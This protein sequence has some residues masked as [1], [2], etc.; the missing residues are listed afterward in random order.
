MTKKIKKQIVVFKIER[1]NWALEILKVQEI[2]RIAEITPIPDTPAFLEGIIN[3]RG[4]VMPI[5]NLRK[6][7]NLSAGESDINAKIIIVETE[8]FLTGFII[9]TV[10]DILEIEEREIEPVKPGSYAKDFVKEII[11][12]E[13]KLIFLLNVNNILELGKKSFSEVL[14]KKDYSLEQKTGKINYDDNEKKK[15]LQQRALELS[16]IPI[17]ENEG[18]K[19]KIIIFSLNNEWY[20]IEEVKIREILNIQKIFFIPQSPNY[21]EGVL[22]ARGM[23]V[24]VVNL[25]KFL[26][27][28]KSSIL[29]SSRIMI[30]EKYNIVVGLLV[31]KIDEIIRLDWDI[32]QHSFVNLVQEKTMFVKGEFQWQNKVVAVLDAENIMDFKI[33]K[34]ASE[35]GS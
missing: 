22:N 23:I 35:K 16:K 9:D 2:V 26:G 11:K 32:L 10:E 15:I 28:K 6:A 13:G 8:G 25:S 20:G 19:D 4:K 1:E 31:D 21:I 29:P 12:L 34:P 5:V 17:E 14:E 7:M 24:P 18:K 30:I 3:L 33:K 27:M